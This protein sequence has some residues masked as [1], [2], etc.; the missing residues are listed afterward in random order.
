MRRVNLTKQDIVK[1]KALILGQSLRQ[2]IGMAVGLAAAYGAFMLLYYIL[3]IDI[4]VCMWVV[5]LILIIASMS[6]VVRINGVSFVSW[7]ISML[8][9]P[10]YLPYQSKGGGFNNDL[11][12]KK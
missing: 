3:G 8:K 2:I 5:F 12:K 11:F 7:I 1:P 6:S 10:I 9:S 4:D